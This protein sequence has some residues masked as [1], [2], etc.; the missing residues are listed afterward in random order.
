MS[1]VVS[2]RKRK[3]FVHVNQTGEKDSFK[4][5]VVLRTKKENQEE[6]RIG[7]TVTK[8]TLG[9]ANVRNRARRRMKEALRSAFPMK[10]IK[11]KGYDYIF[12]AKPGAVTLPLENLKRDIVKIFGKK[13]RLTPPEK[14][15]TTDG[16]G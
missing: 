9:K 1:S 3:D 15:T 12:I 5:F 2:L 8:K 16:N 11:E 13:S 7:I 14:K 10:E 6:D 4:G